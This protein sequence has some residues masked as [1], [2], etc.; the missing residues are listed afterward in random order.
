MGRENMCAVSDYTHGLV[1]G[2]EVDIEL[3]TTI[4]N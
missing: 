1:H 4:T 2:I 3:G